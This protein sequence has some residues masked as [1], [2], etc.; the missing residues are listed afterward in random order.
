MDAPVVVLAGV[1]AELRPPSPLL[2]LAL[3]RP[4]A[5]ALAME[6]A[7]RWALGAIA[8]LECWPMDAAWPVPL[9]PRRWRV[10]EKVAERGGEVFD[11]LMS[12]GAVPLHALLGDIG[13]NGILEDAHAWAESCITA[14]WEVDGAKDFCV[15]RAVAPSVSDSASAA[16]TDSPP[17]GGMA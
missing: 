11:G 3:L 6:P 4:E 17:P 16:P 1:R 8:L 2:A 5:A 15:V 13:V 10:G 9:R 14:R 7:E 12:S